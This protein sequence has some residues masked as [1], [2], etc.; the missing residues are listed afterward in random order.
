M[1]WGFMPPCFQV[2]RRPQ[3]VRR[4]GR[5]HDGYDSCTSALG[6]VRVRRMPA[7]E[8]SPQPTVV[9]VGDISAVVTAVVHMLGFQPA[10]SLVAVALRGPR[11][12]MHFTL[13]VDLPSPSDRWAVAREVT[14]RMAQANADAVML[15]VFTDE[16]PTRLELPHEELVDL[17]VTSLDVDV[18]DAFL[19]ADDRLWSYLC[20]DQRCCPPEGRPFESASPDAVAVAAAHAL[21]G[22]SVLPDRETVVAA[23]QPLGGIVAVSMRQAIERA[24]GERVDEGVDAFSRRVRDQITALTAR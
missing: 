17:V 15:F 4:R 9:R 19:V 23:V 11:E 10:E 18:R 3:S 21:R 14:T 2:V 12:R 7:A 13:R 16:V 24:A 1:M 22:R 8:R 5:P 20:F 6:R